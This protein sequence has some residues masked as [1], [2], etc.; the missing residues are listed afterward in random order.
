M[1]E[2]GTFDVSYA[3]DGTVDDLAVQGVTSFRAEMMDRGVLWLCCYV[4]G[5]DGTQDR[6]AFTVR[7]R[8]KALEFRVDEEPL[9]L[10]WST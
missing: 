5:S 8:G 1:A 10:D 4:E 2:S 7:A 3:P 6:V 9:T